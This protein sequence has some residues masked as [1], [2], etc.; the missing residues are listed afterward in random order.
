M[1]TPAS[2]GGPV[3]PP[4]PACGQ[5]EQ[6]GSGCVQHLPS[7]SPHRRSARSTHCAPRSCSG[8]GSSS[9][10][11]A[12]NTSAW[13]PGSPSLCRRDPRR[14]R[15]RVAAEDGAHT[16]FVSAV[17]AEP[18]T[19]E[20]SPKKGSKLAGSLYLALSQFTALQ[21]QAWTKRLHRTFISKILIPHPPRS[22][23]RTHM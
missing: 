18:G 5:P 15:A 12:A 4:R 10:A 14:L 21:I 16:A 2:R 1:D 20:L 9:G 7:G 6:D 17:R 19:A 8:S 3:T 23:S 22:L 11:S 13:L